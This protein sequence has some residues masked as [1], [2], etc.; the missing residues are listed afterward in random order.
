SVSFTDPPSQ[1]LRT[2]CGPGGMS[3]HGISWR[4]AA[5]SKRPDQ[6]KSMT[7]GFLWQLVAAY[8]MVYWP[9][10]N[11]RVVG[12]NPTAPTIFSMDQSGF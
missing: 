5:T 12:S 6:A 10:L 3:V 8:G 1:H 9:T 4:L 11:Q 2:P 7:Y